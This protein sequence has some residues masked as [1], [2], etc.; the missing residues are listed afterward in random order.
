MSKNIK[1]SAENG[2]YRRYRLFN[3]LFFSIFRVDTFNPEKL[4]KIRSLSSKM[5]LLWR[6]QIFFIK[7][8]MVP[9]PLIPVLTLSKM[10]TMLLYV[11][12][13]YFESTPRVLFF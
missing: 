8:S 5:R 6:A 1:I 2:G 9:P 13:T 10:L 12:S 4:K 11:M 7:S 3:S